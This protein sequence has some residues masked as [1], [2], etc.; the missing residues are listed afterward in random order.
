M[1]T[2][3]KTRRYRLRYWLLCLALSPGY[4]N[5]ILGPTDLLTTETRTPPR[6]RRV[7]PMEDDSVD[8][9]C[10]HYT[11]QSCPNGGTPPN[12]NYLVMFNGNKESGKKCIL[13]IA[14]RWVSEA[15]RVSEAAAANPQL[16][17]SAD[18]SL[19]DIKKML[20]SGTRLPS[21]LAP[22]NPFTG[23]ECSIEDDLSPCT[24]FEMICATGVCTTQSF[25]PPLLQRQIH[26][27]FKR[28]EVIV[29][30]INRNNTQQRTDNAII[31]FLHLLIKHETSA[32][33]DLTPIDK[34]KS[35]MAM[36]VQKELI[37]PKILDLLTPNLSMEGDTLKVAYNIISIKHR[38]LL[39]GSKRGPT[40]FSATELSAF[41]Q[42]VTQANV[43]GYSPVRVPCNTHNKSFY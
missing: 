41:A 30:F 29:H 11:A 43:T 10:P 16:T 6:S 25:V 35:I 28:T 18:S 37:D 21:S 27:V 23:A 22:F 34:Y 12:E 19:D 38:L 9:A 15:A 20:S 7:K 2:E 33:K 17:I 8:T 39:M 5:T 4:I 13:D 26:A 14:A 36:L 42:L 1:P 32:T 24:S 3:P 40:I 31:P